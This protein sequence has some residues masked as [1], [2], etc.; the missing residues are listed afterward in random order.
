MVKVYLD[1]EE[2]MTIYKRR[3]INWLELEIS[4][5][6]K[7]FHLLSNKKLERKGTRV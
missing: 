2:F 7:G 4:K 6:G 3:T 5:V 1:W